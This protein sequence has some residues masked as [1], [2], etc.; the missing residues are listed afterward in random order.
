MLLGDAAII[1]RKDL[2]FE[3]VADSAVR[4]A[5]PVSP[6]L[7]S[8][9]VTLQAVHI[10]AGTTWTPESSNNEENVA[11]IF[12]GHG[13]GSV[14]GETREIIQSDAMHAP[15][16]KVI[17]F[18]AGAEDLEVYLWRSDLLEGRQVSSTADT[19]SSLWNETTQL[20]N[21]AGTGQVSP[22]EKR[23]TMNFVFWPGTGS[24]QMCLHCGIQQPGETFNVHLHQEADEAFIAVEGIGQMYLRDR[25]IDVEAGDV[26][27]A[28]PLILHGARNPHTGPDAR[29]FVTCGGPAP[30][31]PFLYDAAGVSTT[32][33]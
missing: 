11:V 17:S 31:D 16:G 27:Y 13:K 21:F 28:A 4:V 25:W 19:F 5:T 23:A 18:T 20:R 10:P 7:G 6:A 14:G 9:Y 29:R 8:K 30:F 26:L 15:T 12:S 22:D 24:C 32:V 1:R 3:S 33:R 2:K